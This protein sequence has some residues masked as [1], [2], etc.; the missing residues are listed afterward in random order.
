MKKIFVLFLFIIS[1]YSLLQGQSQEKLKKIDQLLYA[2]KFNEAIDSLNILKEKDS[3]NSFIYQKFGIAYQGVFKHRKAKQ[4]LEK[5][6]ELDSLSSFNYKSL[7]LSNSFLNQNK[8][9][10]KNYEKA[11]QLDTTNIS[12]AMSL[13]KIYQERNLFAR[14]LNIYSRLIKIDST[15]S[16]FYRGKAFCNA[17]AGNDTSAI[18]DYKMAIK[19]NKSNIKNYINL[20]ILFIKNDTSDSALVYINKGLILNQNH[21]TLNRLKADLKLNQKKYLEAVSHYSKSIAF[22]DSTYQNYQKLGL[23]YYFIASSKIFPNKKER[24]KKYQTCINT[25]TKSF[26]LNQEDPLTC[27]Y[28]GI[29]Y[30]E[31]EN[32]EKADFYLSASLSNIFPDYLGDVYYQ[33]SD[34]FYKD[35]KLSNSVKLA[36]K[37]VEHS[38]EKFIYVYT[39]ATICDKYYKDKKIALKYYEKFLNHSDGLDEKI[40]SYTKERILAI[41]EKLHFEGRL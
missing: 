27:M 16:L 25:F 28:L 26:K 23:S 24:E 36:R 5:S 29:V 34:T 40:I 10:Q 7:A 39:L 41:K 6:V 21:S 18:A 38:P 37:A 19:L 32:Y 8:E 4:V 35:K 9:A 2:E 30:K 15:N 1:F 11:F 17:K 14:A 12:I 31:L 22:G 13:C 20:A 3:L 33:L